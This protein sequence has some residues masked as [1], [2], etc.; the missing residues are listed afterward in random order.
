MPSSSSSLLA[1]WLYSDIASTPTAS[2]SL[3]MLSDA[4]PFSS[5]SVTAAA[6]TRSLLR[7][8]R[9]FVGDVDVDA[10]FRC[11]SWIGVDNLTV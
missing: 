9:D 10:I 8:V 6:R 4:I 7:G 5:A 11:P 3:R 1:R 2:P